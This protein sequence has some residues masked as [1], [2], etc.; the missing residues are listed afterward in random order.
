[1]NKTA[2]HVLVTGIDSSRPRLLILFNALFLKKFIFEKNFYKLPVQADVKLSNSRPNV[3]T[4][5]HFA[6]PLS[7]KRSFTR[8]NDNDTRISACRYLPHGFTVI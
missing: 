8:P 3:P 6:S 2:V 1:M 4:L 5:E 7:I